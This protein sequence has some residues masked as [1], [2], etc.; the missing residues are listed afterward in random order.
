M[1]V[2]FTRSFWRRHSTSI[3]YERDV[4]GDNTRGAYGFGW[5]RCRRVAKDT[6]SWQASIGFWGDAMAKLYF[7]YSAMNAGKSTTL[8][9]SAHNYEE[10]GMRVL[11]MAPAI[12]DRF[13]K[14]IITSR[15][16]LQRSAITFDAEFDLFVK[17][18]EEHQR[19]LVH[20]VL[21]DEAQFLTAAQVL[22]LTLV[23]DRLNIPVLAYGIRTDFRGE[24]FEGSKYLLAWAEEL[25]EIKTV[26]PSG[27]KATMN[28]R[29]D[30]DGRRVWE[31]AQVDVGNHYIALSRKAFQLEKVSPIQYQIPDDAVV[32]ETS[33]PESTSSAELVGTSRR[34]R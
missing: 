12:D 18:R 6:D 14:G 5:G 22:Q 17:V 2:T 29:L 31:G 8:L 13:G 30:V 25:C 7:Y 9:Q 19:E 28:A 27:K 20:C 4:I 1:P 26:C 10:R 24:P 11:L 23:C 34:P 16:G 15:I 21:V 3:L 33:R 32:D